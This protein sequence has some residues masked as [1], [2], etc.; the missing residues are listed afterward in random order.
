[1]ETLDN[2]CYTCLVKKTM[3]LG[4]VFISKIMR[5]DSRKTVL[6]KSEFTFNNYK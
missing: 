2:F 3:E 4:I 1:M 5:S 6:I